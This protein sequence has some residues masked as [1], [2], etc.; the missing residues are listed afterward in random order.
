MA[1]SVREANEMIIG[2]VQ[3]GHDTL[4]LR[5]MG[6]LLEDPVVERCAVL[7]HTFREPAKK[8]QCKIEQGISINNSQLDLFLRILDTV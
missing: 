5:V 8:D 1:A 7:D 4:Q 2:T 3:R 6:Y